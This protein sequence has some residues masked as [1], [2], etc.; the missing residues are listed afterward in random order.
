MVV[1]PHDSNARFTCPHPSDLFPS[2]PY[3]W[4]MR[5]WRPVPPM[6]HASCAMLSDHGS[7]TQVCFP[8]TLVA[9]EILAHSFECNATILQDVP[10][11]RNGQG[12]TCVLFDQKNCHALSIDLS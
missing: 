4:R 6:I 12:S 2:P 7:Q 1:P 11:L 3:S 10:S 9:Q 8:D 5:F